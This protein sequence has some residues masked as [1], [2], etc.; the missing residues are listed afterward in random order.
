MGTTIRSL[1]PMKIKRHIVLSLLAA[2][3]VPSVLAKPEPDGCYRPVEAFAAS[4]C[5]DSVS[6]D[7]QSGIFRI[8]LFNADAPKPKRSLVIS[9]T[10]NGYILERPNGCFGA[11]VRHVLTA[12]DKGGTLMTGPDM[13]CPTGGDFLTTV[14]VVETLQIN[15]GAGI[16]QNVQPGGTI[17]LKGVLGL[18]TG[19]N[20]FELADAPQD[21]ICFSK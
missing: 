18:T 13:A 9:G 1:N 8:K 4:I 15:E 21:E 16:Y 3:W 5:T 10:F 12:D 7:T 2:T 6:C 20:V 19:T 11:T 14:E 17:T